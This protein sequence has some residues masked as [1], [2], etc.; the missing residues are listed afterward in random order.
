MQ[1]LVARDHAQ[2][3]TFWTPTAEAYRGLGRTYV[4]DARF[5]ATYDAYGPGLA[6]YLRDAMD[7]VASGLG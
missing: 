6:A 4:E 2:V 3:A 7:H 1:A 5:T